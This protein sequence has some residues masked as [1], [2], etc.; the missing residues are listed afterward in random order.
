MKSKKFMSIV[1][2]LLVVCMLLPFAAC[3]VQVEGVEIS[4]ATLTLNI[5]QE[6][7]LTAMVMPQT[8]PQNVTWQSSNTATATV[9][10]NGKVK[11][12][13]EGTALIR[14]S[15]DGKS[16]QCTVTV[17]DP[18]KGV[19]VQSI[20]VNPDAVTLP[21]GSVA[22][23]SA[24]VLPFNAPQDVTWSSNRPEVATVTTTGSVTAV[25]DGVAVI[26]ATAV[27]GKTARCVVT[28]GAG[29]VISGVTVS[30]A[31]VNL[32]VGAT[33]Q[34]TAAVEPTDADQTVTWNTENQAVVTVDDDGL[35]TAQGKGTANVTATAVDGTHVGTCSVT[36]GDA[37]VTGIQLDPTSLTLTLGGAPQQIAVIYEPADAAPQTVNF[38]SDSTG[39]ASVDQNGMVTAVSAGSANITVT[40][41]GTFTATCAVTV[42][43]GG[44]AEGV[45][46]QEVTLDEND[47]TLAPNE[48]KQLTAT[49][50]PEEASDKSVSWSSNATNVARVSQSGLITARAAGTAVITVTTNDGQHTAQCT[51]HVVTKVSGV[52][53]N[54]DNLELGVGETQQIQAIVSPATATDKAVTWH[55]DNEEIASVDGGNVTG[56]RAGETVITVTTNDGSFTAQCNVTVVIKS[57]TLFVSKIQS[58]VDRESDFIMGMDASAVPSLEQARAVNNLGYKNFEGEVE[59]VF[60]ILKDNGITDIRIRIWNDPKTASGDWY[61]GGNCDVNNAVT[62]AQRCQKVGLG[63]IIDFHY[64]DFWADPGKQTAPKAWANYSTDQ[65]ATEIYNFTYESLTKIKATGVTITMV[66]V[67]NEINGGLAGTTDWSNGGDKIICNYIN[68][69]SKAVRAVTG[70][71]EHGGAKVAVHFAN[72][73]KGNSSYAKTLNTYNVDYDVFGSSYYPQWHGTLENLANELRKVHS[74]YNKEVMVL[75]TAW[76]FSHSD[77]DGCGNTSLSVTEPNSGIAPVSVQG[78]A[79]HVH[80]VIQTVSDL[81][82]WGIGICYWEGTWIA[83]STSGKSTNISLC[84][85]YGCGWAKASAR[86][87]DSSATANGGCVIDNQAF[88]Q[89]DGT[90]IESLKVFALVKTGNALAPVA[91]SIADTEGYYTVG[92]GSI[93]LPETVTVTLNNGSVLSVAAMWNVTPEQLEEY[94]NEVGV[95]EVTGTTIYGGTAK[96]I[97]WVMNPNLLEAGSFEEDEGITGNPQSDNLIQSDLGPWQFSYQGNTSALQLYASNEEQNAR[98]GTQSFHFWDNGSVN[99]KLYQMVD[100]TKLQEY[101]DGK[102]SASF[103][104]QGDY[105]TELDIHAYIKVTYKDGTAAKTFEGEAITEFAGWENWQRV[106]VS[107]DDLVL[108][109]V[110]SIEVGISV[111]ATPLSV[112]DEQCPWGN[113]DNAQFYSDH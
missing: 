75:E 71:V 3:A 59:D 96:F 1:A 31:S 4:Q 45:R 28:C 62:I 40:V 52:T 73:E 105:A 88:W 61:G 68:Q 23:L 35:I 90:P 66:Q 76:A 108:S 98:M 111:Y 107:T 19:E 37:A 100:L 60:Q 6:A 64:S 33:R 20:S 56:H 95:H 92:V 2:F 99:F 94:L 48:T 53:L 29:V 110:A 55:S 109:N 79:N 67:G 41:D 70:T 63:V 47:V 78:Q 36:V 39:V 77:F 103:D 15:A 83:A 30:P 87:Y 10:A 85:Q 17:V 57:D 89:S 50:L 13:A 18:S 86:S 12:I 104:F 106:T 25:A 113:I 72:P 112:T 14:A 26:T 38:E 80:N 32:T 8:A 27:G 7:T 34:L 44:G 9:D 91:D 58:L 81:G 43:Q 65:I 102:Y 46:V 82:E 84:T 69:G 54:R 21:L 51:V 42:Q 16:A 97:I 22:T 5:G 11:G 49:V 93:E 24:N 74:S 101:G